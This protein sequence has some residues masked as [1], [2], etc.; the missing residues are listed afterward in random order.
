MAR[1]EVL[2]AA[3]Q[4]HEAT[5]LLLDL[6]SYSDDPVFSTV[7]E[8][9]LAEEGDDLDVI[10]SVLSDLLLV[11]FEALYAGNED[12]EHEE[13]YHLEDV[14][15]AG[16]AE[17][18]SLEDAPDGALEKTWIRYDRVGG[19]EVQVLGAEHLEGVFEDID[20]PVPLLDL[21]VDFDH[22]Q[23]A[24]A[25]RGNTGLL[26]LCQD[27]ADC[28]CELKDKELMVCITSL[29]EDVSGQS[30]KSLLTNKADVLSPVVSDD[31]LDLE[32]AVVVRICPGG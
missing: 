23:D 25:V 13:D 7:E 20:D 2:K 9:L 11:P 24:K 28:D 15:V 4:F 21:H 27:L 8:V 14:F 10:A 32:V 16:S 18:I 26:H 3:L 12:E 31:L 6:E 30:T 19:V 1:V 29:L 17:I 22:V 5:V